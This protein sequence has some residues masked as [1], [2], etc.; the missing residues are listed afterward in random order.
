MMV[1]A[2]VSGLSRGVGREG[3]ALAGVS[4]GR[5]A[6]PC[7]TREVGRASDY[8]NSRSLASS[9]RSSNG[10]EEWAVAMG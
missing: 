8:L 5:L 2:A 6:M 10:D 4:A 7:T 9:N 3:K 1:R